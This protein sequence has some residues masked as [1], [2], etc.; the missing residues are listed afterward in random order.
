MIPTINL[1]ATGENITRL[2]KQKKHNSERT[3][4]HIWI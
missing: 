1:K 2:R 3:P 4:K